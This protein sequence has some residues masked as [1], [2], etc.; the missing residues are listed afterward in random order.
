MSEKENAKNETCKPHL[1]IM[2][3][4]NC[5]KAIVKANTKW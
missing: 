2:L 4:I 1:R 5:E 3:S